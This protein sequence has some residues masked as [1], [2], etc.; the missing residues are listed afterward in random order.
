MG[1][2]TRPAFYITTPIYYPSDRLHIGHAYTTVAADAVAR[3]KRLQGY[4]TYFLT[5]TDEHGQKIERAARAHGKTP[6]EYVDEIVAGIKALWAELRIEYNDFIRTT[7]ERHRDVVKRVFRRL[8][9]Q[10]DIYKAAY[11]GW[12]CTPCETFWTERQ[13]K[14]GNCPDCGRSVELLREESY[15]FRLSKYADSLLGYIE[16]HPDFI[17]PV[18]RRNEMV[19]F[20]KSGL[21]DLC[22][23]R[24]TFSWGIPVPFEPRHV[25]YVWVDAL[26]NYI[27]ALGYETED[28]SLFRRY[29]PADVHLVGK[30]I[31]RFHT[32]IWPMLL[33][34]L[35]LELPRRVVGHGWLLVGGGKMSKSKGNVIDPVQLIEKYG[36]DAV[37]YYLLRELPFGSDGDYLEENVIGRTNSDLANDLGNLLHRTLTVCEK[38]GGGVVGPPGTPE[39]PD[40]ELIELTRETPDKVASLVDRLELSEALAALWQPVAKANKYLDETAPWNLGK[41]PGKRERFNTVVY[42]VLEVYRFVTVLLGP[43][44]P[45]FPERVWPQLGIADRPELH[46]FSSLEWGRF[47]VGAKVQRGVPLFPRI[48]REK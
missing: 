24:T 16:N 29:W 4:D 13:L 30:D 32:I 8:Y 33:M 1:K 35:G 22:V 23:S 26:T 15:F 5:G 25:I 38:F 2:E 18:S 21:E 40:H 37:R 43:F 12:Y 36:V 45:G 19:N 44:M 10:G 47:P 31:V 20:I 27:S 34:A 3:F 7:E 48:E 9:D 11:E 39:G 46:T 14:N 28:D 17:Q 6:E 41:D 42:N